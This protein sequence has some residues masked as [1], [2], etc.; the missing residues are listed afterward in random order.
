MTVYEL[1]EKLGGEIVR[2]KARIR[3]GAEY[4]IVGQLNGDNMEYTAV[5]RQM[6]ADNAEAVE[7]DK[8]KRGRPPKAA[9]VESGEDNIE[10]PQ[11]LT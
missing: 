7:N 3:Q 1:I 4:I 10:A 6:A 9:V 2:G 5:G 11:G 8:P